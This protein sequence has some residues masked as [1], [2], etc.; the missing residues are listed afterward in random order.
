MVVSHNANIYIKKKPEEKTVSMKSIYVFYACLIFVLSIDQTG[1]AKTNTNGIT[2]A[3]HRAVYEM[4]L[5]DVRTGNSVSDLQGRLV[6]EMSGSTCDGYTV[7]MR[8]VTRITDLQGQQRITDLRASSWEQGNGK[9]FRFNSSHYL[10]QRL[11][12]VTS[13]DAR[14]LS[15]TGPIEINVNRPKELSLEAPANVLFPTQHIINIIEAALE[16]KGHL[17]A[18]V[19]DGSEQGEKVYATT[20]IIGKKIAPEQSEQ[21]KDMK[22]ADRLNTLTAWP[23]AIGYYNKQSATETPDYQIAF[24]LYSNGVSRKLIIDYGDFSIAG[25]LKEIEFQKMTDCAAKK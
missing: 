10:N 14:R 12:Q 7:N 16:D 2:L 3:P 6:F 21:L 17:H 15:Q 20:A 18:D 11:D 1:Y 5:K 9:R 22:N 19:Y 25:A 24:Q 8:F 13:G 4:S 23:V